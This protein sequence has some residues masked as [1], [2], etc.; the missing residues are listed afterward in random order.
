M[1]ADASERSIRNF[2]IACDIFQFAY[3]V[4]KHQLRLKHPDFDERTLH[5]ETM[6]LIRQACR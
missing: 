1:Q 2:K 5:E 6:K 4:K 3:D